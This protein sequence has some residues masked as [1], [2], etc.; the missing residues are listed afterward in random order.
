MTLPPHNTG[1]YVSRV[2]ATEAADTA[3]RVKM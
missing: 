2:S 1:F 3:E